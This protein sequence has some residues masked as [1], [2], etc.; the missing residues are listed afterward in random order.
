MKYFFSILFSFLTISL[1]SQNF[2]RSISDIHFNNIM[3][4]LRSD[5]DKKILS[6]DTRIVR[7]LNT[8]I[9]HLGEDTFMVF[10]PAERAIALFLSENYSQLLK[11]VTERYDYHYFTRSRDFI[12]KKAEFPPNLKEVDL[13]PELSKNEDN[14]ILKIN[15]SAL[16][17]DEKHFLELYLASILSHVNLRSF[18]TELMKER[19]QLFLTTFPASR[20]FDYV[21]KILYIRQ[22]TMNFGIGA[23]VFSGYNILRGPVS[24][25]FSNYMPLG[26]SIELGYKKLIV[27]GD[28]S[29]SIFGNIRESF[30]F[31]NDKWANDSTP[32]L[33]DINANLAYVI[34]NRTKTRITPYVGV[35]SHGINLT[36]NNDNI[37]FKP[38]LNCGIEVDWKFADDNS[39]DTYY[40]AFNSVNDKTYWHLRFRL[41]YSQYKISDDRFG[42]SMIYTKFELGFYS[43][44]AKRIRLN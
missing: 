25:Y 18:D 1:A 2:V 43:N 27:K 6:Y 39:Y 10:L 22:K 28:L 20:Y 42:G 12:R 31:R 14:I 11:D 9:I 15:Q 5:F 16:G 26:A 29:T 30:V 23:G 44:P 36:A 8:Q 38:N 40:D 13:L 21:D 41:G 33:T 17:E 19:C 37:R 35:G 34:Y 7:T 4:S 24:D 3:D 32:F